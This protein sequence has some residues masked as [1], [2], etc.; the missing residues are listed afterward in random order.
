MTTLASILR[1]MTST[2]LVWCHLQGSAS[3]MMHKPT[4]KAEVIDDYADLLNLEVYCIQ[5]TMMQGY[6]YLTI[7]LKMPKENSK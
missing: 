5:T 2:D 1:L 6:I 3:L 4:T 7:I